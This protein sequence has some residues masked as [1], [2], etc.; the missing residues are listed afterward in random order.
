[1]TKMRFTLTT[2][3]PSVMLMAVASA[4]ATTLRAFVS[5]TGNDAN[6]ATNCAQTAPCRTFAAAYPTVTAGGEL[7]ALDTAGYGP[8]TGG[9]TINKAITIATIPGVTA[10]VVVATGTTGFTVTAAPTDGVRLRNIS[11][12]GSG[13]A[14]TIGIQHNAGRLVVENCNFQQ[15]TTGVDNY[16]KMDLINCELH[17]N[18]LALQ[19]TGQG[20]YPD[21]TVAVAQLRVNG[22]NITFNTTG[23]RQVNA[24]V[25]ANMNLLYNI[26]VF[27]TSAGMT[28][29][30]GNTTNYACSPA[31]C[32][33]GP[34]VYTMGNL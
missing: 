20:T 9:N 27:A 30:A 7:I 26:F 14:N 18:T 31:S 19:S 5:S 28:N 4:Q 33:A 23:T 21:A 15:L 24:G 32:N 11:F 1:M 6:A 12:N 34:N 16:A 13:A 17:F 10:F 25:N 2:L 29:I 22:G 8:L 3:A